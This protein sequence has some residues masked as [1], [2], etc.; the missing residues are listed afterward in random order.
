MVYSRRIR[1]ELEVGFNQVKDAEK[2][3]RD[4]LNHLAD[5]ELMDYRKPTIQLKLDVVLFRPHGADLLHSD[6][7][8]YWI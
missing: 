6:P 8:V 5:K 4:T 1:E 7:S 3:V 2:V